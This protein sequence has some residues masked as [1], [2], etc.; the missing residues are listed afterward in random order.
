MRFLWYFRVSNYLLIASG[1]LALVITE[2]YG[3]LSAIIF[4]LILLIG[5]KV[6]SGSLAFGLSPLWWNLATIAVLL[7]C[8][9]DALFLRHIRAVALVNFLVFLQ[10][11][12]ILNPKQHQDYITIYVISFF[13][14]LI[15]S[16]MTM[17]ILFALACILF[18]IS[19]TWALITLHL[20][21]EIEAY[22]IQKTDSPGM[23]NTNKRQPSQAEQAS[24]NTPALNGLL[25]IRFFLG[26]LGITLLTF[27]LALIIFTILP[28]VREGFFLSYGMDLT[29][30][31]S[32]FSEEVALDSFGAIRLNY[33]PVMRITLP[34]ISDQ[35]QLPMK[36]Y[37][38]GL[39]YN[40]YNG[41][42]WR[43]DVR[44]WKHLS[45]QSRYQRLYWF[46]RRPSTENLLAQQ[47]ELTSP[48]F[49]VL[50]GSDKVYAVEGKFL[51]LQYDQVTDNTQVVFDP[52]SLN[53]TIYSDIA[54]PPE[55]ALRNDRG[56]YPNII[57]YLY[58][59]LPEL[60]E[61]I[62]ELA[63]QIG[64]SYDNAYDKASAIQNF[65]MQ[66][67]EYSLDV[68]RTP[69]L[70]PLEDF[71]FVNKAGHCEYYATSM[72]ILL[73]I[74][75]VP[76]RVVNG[77]A[78]GRWNEFGHFFTVRQSDAHAWV[79]VFFPSHGWVAF[80]P[81]PEAAFG[82]A[83]RQF[84]ERKSFMASLY[85]Y[86]EYLRVRWN[87]YIVDYSRDDQAQALFKAVIATRSTQQSLKYSMDH[88]IRRL[89]NILM[90]QISWREIGGIVGIVGAGI[91]FIWGLSRLCSHFHIRFPVFRKQRKVT[92]KKIIQFYHTMLHILAKKGIIKHSSATPGEF[93]RYVA[94]QHA[95]Y[96]NDVR[97]L[98]NL[99]YA[100]RYGHTDLTQEDLF[101]TE[102]LL[103]RMKKT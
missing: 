1:F 56:S 49:D 40:Y 79:E 9:A 7:V 81:T 55:E 39:S 67:Y 41:K 25:N 43:T 87:R 18:V 4:A 21:K 44:K 66:N 63:H 96:E 64:D 95:H 10:T 103:R 60:A 48:G 54:V 5:W 45:V 80:D 3:L 26:T 47:V 93:A 69:N 101:Y 50:F 34:E 102:K 38:K 53:Y 62:Q 14:L 35:A 92:R 19:A 65:L 30:Q 76:T 23:G 6:D 33:T 42:R 100:V 13:E 27:I 97:H 98:T 99:Y 28:R 77:F 70:L 90:T 89:K 94:Q 8:L 72:A 85:R 84:A 16:I 52:F 83:Y 59:Q 11:T 2:Y 20:K 36:L 46:H 29:P 22:I 17:S 68:Q 51:S 58:L 88:L 37:W 57:T 71:L 75:G 15:S 61:R 78:Q 73:R 91:L 86:S 24:F 31:V 12:K 82:D 74:L 32:G